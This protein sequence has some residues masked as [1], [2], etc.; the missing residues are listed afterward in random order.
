MNIYSGSMFS[1]VVIS[2]ER[3][4]ATLFYKTYEQCPKWLGAW[5]GLAEVLNN[6]QGNYYHENFRY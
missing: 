6:I 3:F 2:I 5:F 4:I 1:L